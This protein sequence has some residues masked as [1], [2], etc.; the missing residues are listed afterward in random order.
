MSEQILVIGGG[1]GGLATAIR[2]A[3]AGQQVELFEARDQLGGRASVYQ[4][5][6]F[7]FDGG[8]TVITAPFLF[9][10]LF[11]LAGRRRQDYVEFVPLDPFYRI[12]D[13]TGRWFDYNGDSSFIADQIRRWNPADVDGYER[14]IGTTQAIFQKGFVELADRPF[15]HF[16]DMLRIAPELVRLQSYKSVYRFVSQFVQDE[17]LRRCFS[18]HPLLI[19]GKGAHRHEP[20]VGHRRI[21]DQLLHV[22]LRQ[23]H[24]RGID[25]G[26]GRQPQNQR[27]QQVRGDRE[28]RQAETQEAV[29]AHFQK[30]TGQDNG[31]RRRRLDMGVGQPG[32]NGPHRHLDGKGGKEGDVD[33][34]V[35]LQP[36]V[37]R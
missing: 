23:R 34:Q 10:E 32:M 30:D 22:L 4:V 14:F 20:H 2:L 36:S 15:L 35:T 37:A 5:N 7:T 25:D 24:Q 6:G 31:T 8:P 12:F 13:H 18:F 9:D 16:R 26:N 28:H 29:S 27:G 3:A 1:F 17:F 19:G 11:S 33:V 21:G